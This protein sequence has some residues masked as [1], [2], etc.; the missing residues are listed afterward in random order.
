MGLSM[1][2]IGGWKFLQ[3]SDRKLF[4]DFIEEAVTVELLIGTLSRDLVLVMHYAVTS[5]REGL[6][7]MMQCYRR[8]HFAASNDLHEHPRGHSS[9][10]E[11]TRMEFVNIQMEYSKMRSEPSEYMW[12][13]SVILIHLENYFGEYAQEVWARLDESRCAYN[14]VGHE[15]SESYVVQYAQANIDGDDSDVAS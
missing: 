10:R 4:E 9:W 12:K 3:L 5:T 7:G 6:H 14:V 15:A 13:T 2:D 11:S 1:F 8:Q